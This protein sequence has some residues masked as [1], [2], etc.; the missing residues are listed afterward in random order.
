MKLGSPNPTGIC[1][2]LQL[3]LVPMALTS[4]RFTSNFRLTNPHSRPGEIKAAKP[5]LQSQSRTALLPYGTEGAAV[6]PGCPAVTQ[7]QRDTRSTRCWEDFVSRPAGSLRVKQRQSSSPCWPGTKAT[8]PFGS[9]RPAQHDCSDLTCWWA[10]T[11]HHYYI[12]S[13]EVTS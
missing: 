7:G 5:A 12:F 11:A 8:C 1:V 3:A 4:T 9:P 2:N 10:L 6:E 13:L